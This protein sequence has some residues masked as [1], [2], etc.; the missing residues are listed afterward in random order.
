MRLN[1]LGSA[2]ISVSD[3]A[4]KSK[5]VPFRRPLRPCVL[6]YLIELD[7]K[8]IYIFEVF[9]FILHKIFLFFFSSIPSWA[10]GT[11]P[12]VPNG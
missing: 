3:A 8:K 7:L 5:S 12:T 1:D 9:Y 6:V 10:L 2:R 4:N 11:V